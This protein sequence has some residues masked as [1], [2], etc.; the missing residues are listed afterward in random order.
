MAEQRLFHTI[1][2][3]LTKLI[4]QG[5]FPPGSRL[6]GERELAERFNVSRVTIREAEIALQAIGRIDIRTGAGVYVCE[7]QPV[8]PGA[9][10]D[11]SAFELTEAR[12]LIEGEAAALA[13]K[14]ISE[15]TLAKL[16]GL[17]KEMASADEEVSTAADREF[18]STIAHASGNGAL[19]HTIKQLWR[20]REELP[21]V[22]RSYESVCDTD[23]NARAREHQEIFDAL[24]AHDPDR[25]R[26]AMRQHFLRLISAMLDVTEKQAMQEVR[27]RATESR[28]RFL[29]AS[30]L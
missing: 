26:S 5:V 30:N 12:S 29:A 23:P 2:E 28:E 27:Q 14:M 10:P 4:E 1:A 9:L 13:A 11:V 15:A 18:H 25:A 22:K 16:E 7:E 24:A 17:I 20:M 8:H 3:Q 19:V 6:P 21:T